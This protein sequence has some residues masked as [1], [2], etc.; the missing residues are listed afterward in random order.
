MYVSVCV[1]VCVC[2]YKSVAAAQQVCEQRPT[3]V[4]PCSAAYIYIYMIY[5]CHSKPTSQIYIY[6]VGH[7]YIY[8]VGRWF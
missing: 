2:A 4:G 8:I 3:I 1:C 7:R 6:I 5:S